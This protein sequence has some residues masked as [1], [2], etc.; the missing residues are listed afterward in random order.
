[1]DVRMRGGQAGHRGSPVANVELIE[2]MRVMQARME[3][4]ELG[5]HRELDLGDVSDPE[6]EGNE[7]EEEASPKSVEMKMLR[8]MLG[9]SSRPKPSLSTYDGNLS[10]E[11][12]IDWIGKLDRYFDYEE[13]E[14]DKKVKLV[15]TRLKGHATLWWDNLQAKRKKKNKMVIK[16]WDRMVAKMRGKL[17]PK[18]YQLSLYK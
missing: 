13:I 16:S 12:L 7:Q 15:V 1:M 3:A 6:E 4:M 9:S 17:L 10:A 8:S 5:R 2:K 18:D 11:G 14:E